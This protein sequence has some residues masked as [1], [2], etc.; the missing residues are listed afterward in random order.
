MKQARI[1]HEELLLKMNTVNKKGGFQ[2]LRSSVVENIWKSHENSADHEIAKHY[3]EFAMVIPDENLNAEYICSG[4]V[5]VLYL[6]FIPK[7]EL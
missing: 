2:N 5:V 7:K 1:Y 4:D 6:L 3:L